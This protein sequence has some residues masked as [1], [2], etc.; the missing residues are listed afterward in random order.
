MANYLR[1]VK[2][3]YENYPYPERDPED[4]KKRLFGTVLEPLSKINHYCFRGRRDLTRS[5]R[6]LLAGGGTGDATIFL[7]EQLRDTD[8][9]IIHLDISSAS[10]EVAK[11]RA[12]V[13][14]LENIRWLKG[15][16]LDLPEL[17][18]GKFDYI[19]CTG[20]LHH[21]EDPDEGLNMLKSVLKPDGAMGI[22]VYGKYGRTGVYQIQ[23]LMRL[24]NNSEPDSNIRLER[25]KA[26]LDSLPKT[27]WFKR[28]EYLF[29]NVKKGN[30]IEIYDAFLH[31]RDRAYTVS[32]I[33]QWV[34][35]C[36]LNFIDF[37]ENKPLYEPETFIKNSDLLDRIKALPR[38]KQ[39]AITEIMVGIH[40]K[41]TFYVSSK[42]D[43]IAIFQDADIIPFFY[44]CEN[45]SAAQL[46]DMAAKKKVGETISPKHPNK[47][48]ATLTIGKYT[49]AVLK[50]LD[51]HN[52]LG[53]ILKLVGQEDEFKNNPPSE[54]AI[55]ADLKHIY[56]L[57]NLMD[58]MVIRHKSIGP[59]KTYRQM[60]EPVTQRYKNG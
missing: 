7:A 28:G 55:L 53:K 34:S 20:V 9:E 37:A 47:G 58:V 19:N 25:A 31:S 6:V 46:Y 33:Y 60:Q 10:M 24:I 11:K 49:K 57:F 13:R 59:Y 38:E 15:S 36:G 35:R 22:M 30:D 8:T 48:V 21:L 50:Y 4:E 14:G 26:V 42:K 23:E 39:Q 54:D 29:G 45:I 1:S 51:G 41:H 17:D 32:Q 44:F 40:K 2:E 5:F 43:T 52:S 16:L 27:N 18:I 3:Q 12:R 56:H